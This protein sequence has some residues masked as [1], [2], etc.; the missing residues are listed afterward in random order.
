MPQKKTAYNTQFDAYVEG[1]RGEIDSGIAEKQAEI[2]LL[3]DKL[4]SDITSI[5][6]T[7][8]DDVKN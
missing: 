5:K 3:I 6:K 8:V 4:N 1:L 2:K 7:Y